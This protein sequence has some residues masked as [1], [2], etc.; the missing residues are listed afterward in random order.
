MNVR[1]SPNQKIKVLNSKDVYNVMQQILLR[2]NK[3]RRKQ[4]HFWIVGLDEESR[5]LFI[6]LLSLGAKNMVTID[7]PE[8]FRMAVYKMAVQTI[9]IHNHPSG[10]LNPS[11]EDKLFT[12]TMI[13]AGK[14]IRIDVLDHLIITEKGFF[15]M[16]ETGE[17]DEVRKLADAALSEEQLKKL[18]QLLEQS[19]KQGE[20]EANIAMAKRLLETNLLTTTQIRDITGLSIRE[21]N[22]L[23]K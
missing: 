2:E 4:E 16:L 22:K 14:I 20:R 1:L 21:M 12:G 8:V 18:K 11:E 15:S 3:I 10:T 19:K 17:M 5:I 6:E 9:L 23:T 13:N 7:P